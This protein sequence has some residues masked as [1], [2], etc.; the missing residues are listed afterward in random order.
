MYCIRSAMN[1]KLVKQVK[2]KFSFFL[3]CILPFLDGWLVGL[4]LDIYSSIDDHHFNSA[5]STT[6]DNRNFDTKSLITKHGKVS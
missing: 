4:G 1:E 2:K 6:P 5:T 3:H